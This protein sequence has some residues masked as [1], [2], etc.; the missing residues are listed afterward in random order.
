MTGNSKSLL[1]GIWE[2]IASHQIRFCQKLKTFACML[3][4]IIPGTS[5]TEM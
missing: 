1:P 3:M 4:P 5:V 2:A